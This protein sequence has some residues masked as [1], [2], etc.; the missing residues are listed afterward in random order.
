MLGIMQLQLWMKVLSSY[1]NY[2]LNP[3]YAYNEIDYR[4][5][6]AFKNFKIRLIFRNQAVRY[7]Q[8]R[9]EWY[10]RG[11]FYPLVRT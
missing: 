5:E 3:T 6:N 11:N 10:L 8:K 2:D 9:K 4:S 1:K 7:G